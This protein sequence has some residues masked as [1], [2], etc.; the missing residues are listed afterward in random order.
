MN[1]SQIPNTPR[2][3]AE[4]KYNSARGNLILMI[5]LTIVN[6]FLLFFGSDAFLLFS[7]TVPYFSAATGMYAMTEVGVSS[8]FIAVCFGFAA[9]SIIAYVLC[10]IL[11]KKHYGW[12]IAAL[13]MFI[14][15]TGAMALMYLTAQD[16]SGILDVLIHAWVLYYLISGTVNGYKLTTLPADPIPDEI[17]ADPSEVPTAPAAPEASVPLR[18]V[19]ITVKARILLEADF[20][21]HHIIYRRVKRTNELVIDSHVYAEMEMLV[22]PPHTLTAY[23]YG[24][25]FQAGNDGQN[26][27]I[28]VNGEQI[29]KKLRLW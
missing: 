8:A 3:V 24:Y 6:V 15:D 7:A 26:S 9:V 21:G 16:V 28:N 10:W 11:S 5:V 2:A 27:F 1:P 13:V 29:A 12:M 4:H 23:L 25:E 20:A 22:E 19:D 18:P 14:V 17:P